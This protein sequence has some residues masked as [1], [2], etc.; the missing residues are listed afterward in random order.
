VLKGIEGND[1][2]RVVELTRH[3]VGNDRFEVCSLD[4]GFA[5]NAQPVKA[6]N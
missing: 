5:V 1:A 3:Q 2:N 4:F 6:V